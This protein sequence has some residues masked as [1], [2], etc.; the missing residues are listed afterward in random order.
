MTR[1][2]RVLSGW[3]CLIVVGLAASGASAE[4]PEQTQQRAVAGIDAVVARF[5]TTGV[6]P[7]PSAFGEIKRSLS[8]TVEAFSARGDWTAVALSQIKLGQTERMLAHWEEAIGHFDRAAMSARRGHNRGREAKALM[9]RAK[10][11]EGMRGYG[12]AAEHASAAVVLADLEPDP[13]LRFDTLDVLAEVQ[14]S[15]ND[16]D[17]ARQTLERAFAVKGVPDDVLIY[18]YLDRADVFLAMAASHDSDTGQVAVDLSLQALAASRAQYLRAAEL[19]DRLKW[20][21]LGK[22]IQGFLSDVNTREQMIRRRAEMLSHLQFARLFHPASASDV[23]VT[24]QFVTA[25]APDAATSIAPLVQEL[26]AAQEKYGGFALTSAATSAFTDGVV[27]QMQGDHPG[28]LSQFRKA[29]DIVERDRQSMPDEKGRSL[30]LDRKVDMYAATIFELLQQKRQGE[31]FALM[32]QSRARTAAELLA[33]RKLDLRGRTEQPL[34]AESVRLRSELAR[35]QRE[36]MQLAADRKPAQ[37]VLAAQQ[38]IQ[39]LEEAERRHAARIAAE[40]PRLQQLSVS[41]PLSLEDL[42]VLARAE[43]CDF[44]EYMV[45][46]NALT[47]WHIGAEGTQVRNVF[48]PRKD[49]R[50]AVLALR[51]TLLDPG[52]AFDHKTARELYLML[53]EPMRAFLNSERLVIVPHDALVGLPLQALEE[54]A[55]GTPLGARYQ[56]SY[57]PSATLYN[58]LRPWSPARGRS[59]LVVVDPAIEAAALERES[60]TRIYGGGARRLGN[61]LPT[62][63]DLVRAVDGLAVIHLSVHGTFDTREPML[64]YL[65]LAGGREEGRLTAAEMFGLPLAKADLVVLSACESGRLDDTRTSDVFGMLRGLLFAGAGAV[66]VSNWRVD[67]SSTALWMETFH[68]AAQTGSLAFAARQALRAVQADRRFLHP[69][70]WAAFSVIGRQT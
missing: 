7:E 29:I 31:A 70:Y 44:L 68:R 10:A 36:V 60:V 1:C 34:Y 53:F 21:G 23:L 12:P 43:Q 17:G 33:T 3:T 52:L 24:E 47:V 19:T 45:T 61:G 48:L 64:S 59:A 40:A 11:E 65:R 46:E 2:G 56:I 58:D 9:E 18:G 8:E 35:A 41:P 30:F 49:L 13:T 27:H 55:T 26:K 38:R 28:A 39:T 4:T 22:Q 25:S 54:P 32:E 15:Q 66:V 51:R 6:R 62:K 63:A 69:F 16:L 67:A 57:A 5:R 42:Q 37:L 14:V 50:E 20:S